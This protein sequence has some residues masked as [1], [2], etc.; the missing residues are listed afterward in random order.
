MPQFKV[1]GGTAAQ[2][3]PA[4]F[5]SERELQRLFEANL[6][7][8]LGVRFVATEFPTGERHGGRIDTLGLDEQGSPVIIEYNWDRSDSVIN[9]GLF[10]LDWLLDHRGDFELAAQ[11]ALG[12]GVRVSWDG[13]R[14]IL[15]ASSYTKYDA[16]AVHRLGPGIELLRYQRYDDGTL[17]LENLVEPIDTKQRRALPRGPVRERVQRDEPQP[18][19]A[20]GAAP[21]GTAPEYGLD[22]HPLRMTTSEA[23]W[24]AFLD[25]RDRVLALEGVEEQ[26]NTKSRISYRTAK[27]FAAFFFGKKTGYC[28]FKGGETVDDPNGRVTDIRR[29]G[30]GYPWSCTFHGPAD[31]DY[32][33]RLV[34]AAYEREQ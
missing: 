8:L 15:V 21:E 28:I 17:V 7:V 18:G 12:T 25:V 5:G 13:P 1:A 23:V 24:A 10:Y 11:R 3:T 26:A 19:E 29:R 9:Q 27:G 34:K 14:L 4:P 32:V 20:Q 31:V 6:E 22:H 33:F 16:Y 30:W 2:L